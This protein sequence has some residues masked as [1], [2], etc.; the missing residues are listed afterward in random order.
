MI[1]S[2]SVGSPI[3]TPMSAPVHNYGPAMGQPL[4]QSSSVWVT[5][6]GQSMGGPSSAPSSWVADLLTS[7]LRQLTNVM[8]PDMVSCT[9]GM[10]YRP[11]YYAQHVLWNIPIKSL[12][13]KK[14]S[15]KSLIYGMTCVARHMLSVGGNDDA[16]LSHIEFISIN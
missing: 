7:A 3:M 8:D 11:E 10:I 12:D 13:H 4:P 5:A 1:M 9:A 2:T 15:Y 16:Y 6:M 14:L